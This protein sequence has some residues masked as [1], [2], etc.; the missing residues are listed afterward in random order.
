[1]QKKKNGMIIYGITLFILIVI[2][3][4]T[5]N[6]Y[7]TLSR[8]LDAVIWVG[9]LIDT[10]RRMRQSKNIWQFIKHHPFDMLSLIPVYNGFRFFKFIPLIANLIRLSSVGKR[11]VLPFL[12]RLNTTGVGRILLYFLIVFFILPI[13]LVFVEPQMHHSYG[14]VLW[15]A[16][17]TVTT[18]GYGNIVPV[19][20]I[21]KMIASVLMVLGVGMISTITSSLTSAIGT[22]PLFLGKEKE[23]QSADQIEERAELPDWTVEDIEYLQQLLEKEKQ[24]LQ[25]E[26]ESH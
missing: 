16:L 18:V 25:K 12:Q 10:V 3:V 2:S 17:Q 6:R 5:T 8:S 7:P 20:I 9:F 19:T 13:P 21:G 14:T 24:R 23:S 26:T 1:M 22:Q 11:Y 15:W 4:A